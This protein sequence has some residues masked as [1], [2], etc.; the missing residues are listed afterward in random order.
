VAPF[1]AAAPGPADDPAG[2]TVWPNQTSRANSDRWLVE[3]HDRIRRMN[4]RL[5]LLNFSNACT[6]EHLDRLTGDLLTALAE[7]SRYHGYRDSNAPAFLNYQV[8]K[9]VD[10]RDADKQEGNSTK[11]PFKAKP[12]DG[13]N[14]DYQQFFE[15]RFAEF[16]GVRDPTNPA[17]FLRLNEL[18]DRGYVHEVWFFAEHVKDFRAYEVVEEKPQYDERFQRMG[19]KF[20]QAG[21][22]GDADQKWTGRSV[23]IGFINASRGIGCFLESLSHGI[24]GMAN[25]RAIPYFTRYFYEFAGHDLDARYKLPWNSF[26]PLWGEGKEIEYP[27]PHTAIVKDGTRSLRLENYVAFGGNVHFPPNG[28]RHYDLDNAQPVMST[29]E[30][31]RMGSGPAGKDLAR[32]WTNE[33]FARYRGMAPDCMGPWLV[34]W[35]QNFPGL[36]NKQKDDAGRPMKNWWPFLFY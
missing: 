6:R 12:S 14:I 36:D 34:Y 13:F 33:A 10:L 7:G 16:Y 31:W 3:H 4:P 19:D 5:L 22:G 35:R 26:Y 27:D 18:V 21:N 2:L 11:V 20:A 1:S 25:S 32:P 29:I 28:R 17:R 15:D 9:F 30:D 24:E 23:R 8:F